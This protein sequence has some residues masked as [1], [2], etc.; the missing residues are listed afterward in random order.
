MKDNELIEKIR[1][2]VNSID[3][4]SAKYCSLAHDIRH[5]IVEYERK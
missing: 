5:L 1:K 3:C 4:D 2:I